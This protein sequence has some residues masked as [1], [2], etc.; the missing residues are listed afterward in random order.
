[1]SLPDE[2]RHWTTPRWLSCIYERLLQPFAVTIDGTLPVAGSVDVNNFPATQPVTGDFYPATQPV[3]GSVA[4]SNLPATQP[5]S[6]SVSVTNTG[7]TANNAASEVYNYT[8]TGAVANGTIL[9]PSTDCS[10]LR[11]VSVHLVSA[12]SGFFFRLE[13][14]N[15]NIN[16]V[17]CPAFV[18]NGVVSIAQYGTAGAIYTYN[19][20][21]ARFFRI[22]QAAT[23]TAG[24]TT[25]V[26]YASQQATPKL[27]Q[28][29]TGSVTAAPN[30]GS[31][32]QLPS[33]YISLAGTNALVISAGAS[34]FFALFITNTTAFMKFVKV[35]NRGT[36]PTI[37]TDVPTWTI[38]VPPMATIDISNSFAGA[39]FLSGISIGITGGY[40][41]TDTTPVAAG[42][43]IVN[44]LR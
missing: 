41:V 4:V 32:P 31:A 29:V 26:A 2:C 15:N 42:D 21:G 19:L 27:Y 39:R 17:T 10:L 16:W 12:G 35:Y 40:A 38:G 37:G 23:Q 44:W 11:E 22:V 36:L 28:S 34:N 8:A 33:S 13:L 14:S 3:S 18:S 7:F 1:M 20:L 6:G 24:T 30:T 43:V 9:V 25:L 5:V